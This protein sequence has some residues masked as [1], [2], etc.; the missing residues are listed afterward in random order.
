MTKKTLKRYKV[1]RRVAV[2]MAALPL[3]QLSQCSTGIRQIAANTANGLPSAYNQV[4]S[5]L[6]WF[7]AQALI[8]A[9]FGMSTG[10]IGNDGNNDLF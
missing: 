2:F 6:L 9:I 7:P 4:V 5:S 8:S 3:L 1:A 10:G